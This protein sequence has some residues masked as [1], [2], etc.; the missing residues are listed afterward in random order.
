M[1]LIGAPSHVLLIKQYLAKILALISHEESFRRYHV[2]LNIYNGLDF[3]IL[4][5]QSK[6]ARTKTSLKSSLK[7]KVSKQSLT[8]V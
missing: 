4:R 6:S 3:T 5:L 2:P 8:E 1:D 7:K